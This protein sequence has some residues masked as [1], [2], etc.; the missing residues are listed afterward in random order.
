VADEEDK[1]AEAQPD[2]IVQKSE[3]EKRPQKANARR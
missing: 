2:E 3:E 1:S